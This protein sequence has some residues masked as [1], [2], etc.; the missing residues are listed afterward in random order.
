MLDLLST[1]I[2]TLLIVP[3][4][5][6]TSSNFENVFSLTVLILI[7]VPTIMSLVNGAPFVPTPMKRVKKMVELAKLKPGQRV[8]DIGCGDGRFVYLAANQYGAKATGIEL[9]PM[10]YLYAMLRKLLWG[11]KAKIVF[12]NF[13]HMDLSDA[14][15]IFCYLLPDTL[16]KIQPDLDKQLK[17]GTRIISYAFNIPNWKLIHQEERNKEENI[18]QVLV[19]EK[20]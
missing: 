3:I 15:V 13:K 19:Y 10:V 9:S 7:G 20:T 12:G 5:Y 11:S 6:F 1:L 2:V 14:D 8:Y 16:K 4:L 17:P 18:S